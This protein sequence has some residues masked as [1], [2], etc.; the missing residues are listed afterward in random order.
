MQTVPQ[1][2]FRCDPKTLS[3]PLY[4]K[5][6]FGN[7]PKKGTSLWNT[8]KPKK[9]EQN[10]H[11]DGL[12]RQKLLFLPPMVLGSLRFRTSLNNSFFPAQQVMYR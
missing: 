2:K 9:T 5:S 6:L 8:E 3:L 12:K 1:Q 4:H 7:N 11:T 10:F